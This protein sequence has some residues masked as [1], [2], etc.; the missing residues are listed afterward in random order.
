[1]LHQEQP[2]VP[3][4]FPSGHLQRL[5]IE[6]RMPD[7]ALGKDSPQDTF[8]VRRC[9]RPPEIRFELMFLE[10]VIFSVLILLLELCLQY[11]AFK[12]L[13]YATPPAS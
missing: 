9:E 8:A 5:A 1:M 2:H 4:P 11:V 12:I 7:S 6:Y 13:H 10:L 3:F